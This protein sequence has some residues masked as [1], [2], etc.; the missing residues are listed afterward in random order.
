MDVKRFMKRFIGST[1]RSTMRAS[2]Q[3]G[4]IA[5]TTVG[6]VAVL[7][8][9]CSGSS[10]DGDNVTLQLAATTDVEQAVYDDLIDKFEAANPGINVETAFTPTDQFQTT[11]PRAMGSNN[12]PDI[13][14]AF[15]GIG[16]GASAY[17]LQDA[18]LI[19]DQADAPWA[20]DLTDAQR[21]VLGHDG[22]IAFNPIGADTIGIVYDTSYFDSIGAEAPTTWSGLLD[23][24]GTLADEGVTPISLGLQSN[25]VTQFIPYALVASTVYAEDPEFDSEMLAGRG[26]FEDSGWRTALEKF[27]ALRDA[28]CFA[29]T[30]S[31]TTYE[32]MLQDLATGKAAMTVTVGPSLGPIREAN[33]DGDYAMAPL[34]AFD[35]AA[36]NGVPQAS[37]IG[38]VIN[39]KSKHVDAARKFVDFV[40]E[41][42]NLAALAA[43]YNVIPR[44]G[45]APAGLEAMSAAFEEQPTG[46]FPNQLWKSPTGVDS[47]MAAVQQLFSGQ[48][49]VDGVL[50]A[51]DQNYEP[52]D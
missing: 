44:D 45:A 48:N 6:M 40:N 13:V 50:E 15:P 22:F 9:S 20:A 29:E 14:A 49:T 27:E 52:L 33:P 28:G 8:A 32:T 37:S 4:I 18:D 46:I 10:P 41:P 12:G 36:E 5:A 24:C 11:I 21:S 17:A 16:A 51:M 39:K 38:L 47:Y 34:P 19:V 25:F 3:R 35:D 30:I 26:S 23:L 43:G 1:E 31:G 7:L 42:E 2:L